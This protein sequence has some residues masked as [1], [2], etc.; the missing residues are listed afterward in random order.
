MLFS[1]ACACAGGLCGAL[2]PAWTAPQSLEAGP[3]AEQ[4][5]HGG[6]DG[7]FRGAA[8][9]RPLR[10]S[11]CLGRQTGNSSPVEKQMAKRAEHPVEGGVCL[12]KGLANSGFSR[13]P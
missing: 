2:D 3:P 7:E 10:R 11:V 8:A 9:L 4:L 13:I 12:D 6:A 5:G 1:S